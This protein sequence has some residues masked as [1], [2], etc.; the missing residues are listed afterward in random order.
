MQ[1]IGVVNQLPYILDSQLHSSFSQTRT[2]THTHTHTHCRACVHVHKHAYIHT[3]T[4]IHT[5]SYMHTH[6][7]TGYST[8]DLATNLPPL[9]S[10]LYNQLYTC[11]AT[12]IQPQCG[13]QLLLHAMYYSYILNTDSYSYS[14]LY[15]CS[16][17]QL[18]DK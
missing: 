18:M 9:Y 2:H 16:I 10:Q 14:Y 12:Y 5:H 11:I 1:L 17:S 3:C 15:A 13:S 6:I 8:Q 7:H 4:Y